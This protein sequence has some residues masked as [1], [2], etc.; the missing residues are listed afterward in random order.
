M[1]YAYIYI[2]QKTAYV[3]IYFEERKNRQLFVDQF[4]P[5]THHLVH[6]FDLRSPISCEKMFYIRAMLIFRR[7]YKIMEIRSVLI[8]R[9]YVRTYC[10]CV[11]CIYSVHIYNFRV[12]VHISHTY[13]IFFCIWTNAG[14]GH[15]PAHST[16]HGIRTF[17]GTV[18]CHTFGFWS[19]PFFPK[20]AKIWSFLDFSRISTKPNSTFF[21]NLK[22]ELCSHMIRYVGRATVARFSSIWCLKSSISWWKRWFWPASNIF[23]PKVFSDFDRDQ[24]K[25]IPKHRPNVWHLTVPP[26]AHCHIGRDVETVTYIEGEHYLSH[27]NICTSRFQHLNLRDDRIVELLIW[28]TLL[29]LLSFTA[30][31]VFVHTETSNF[32]DPTIWVGNLKEEGGTSPNCGFSAGCYLRLYQHSKCRELDWIP[33]VTQ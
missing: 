30:I 13:I 27:G 11:N 6:E 7:F 18:E 25:V 19:F 22:D 4:P 33:L 10:A 32:W 24:K 16:A 17:H 2:F 28:Q 15:P 23:D 3:H 12:R 5:Y 20:K 31:R 9:T 14:F 8:V 29:V 26:T 21:Y 1:Q